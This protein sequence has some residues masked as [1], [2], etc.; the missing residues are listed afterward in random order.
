MADVRQ[1]VNAIIKD[2]MQYSDNLEEGQKL[3]PEEALLEI[4]SILLNVSCLQEEG[5]YSTF[6]VCFISPDSEYLEPYV[7]SRVLRFSEEIELS[8]GKLHKLSPALNADVSYLM[9]D[10][11]KKP[12]S[13]IGIL[14][15]YTSLFENR[16]TFASRRKPECRGFRTLW[17]ASRESWSSVSERPPWYSIR[18]EKSFI[19][20]G[21]IHL[22]QPLWR[23]SCAMVQTLRRQTDFPSYIRS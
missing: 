14:S 16:M 17:S 11:S 18:Q 8:T 1:F 20:H 9:L 10:A 6:R 7:Y 21:Q 5:R 19:T 23:I 22:P 4:C 3:P 15:A 2:Y 13:I 12:Y